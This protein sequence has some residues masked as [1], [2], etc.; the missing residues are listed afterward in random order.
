[1]VQQGQH[2]EKKILSLGNTFHADPPLLQAIFPSPMEKLPDELIDHILDCRCLPHIVFRILTPYTDLEPTEIA[3]LQGVSKRLLKLAR[4]GPLWRFQCYYDSPKATINRIGQKCWTQTPA[5]SLVGGQQSPSENT[6]MSKKARATDEWDLSEPSEKI[7]WYSEYVARHAQLSASWLSPQS[8]NYQDIRGAALFEDND[9]KKLVG[10]LEDGSLCLW[11]LNQ[12][13]GGS[14]R[15]AQICQK[16]ASSIPGILFSDSTTSSESS[17]SA[18]KRALS[19]SGVADCIS[20]DHSRK[21]AYVAVGDLLN[22]VDLDTL[23]V[24]SQSQ[25]A[26]SITALSQIQSPHQSLTV[27]TSFSLHILDPRCPSRDRSSSPMRSA[28]L[29]ES[30][31]FFPNKDIERNI[32]PARTF[33]IHPM[34]GFGTIGRD[35]QSPSHTPIPT[36]Y[37]QG[38]RN[39]TSYAQL[40]PA[41]L[42]ILHQTDNSIMVA[43]RFPS[44]LNYDRRYFPR[45]E[46][47]IHSSARLSALAYLPF[48]P[49]A[50]KYPS[51]VEPRGTLISCGEYNG[52]G[53]LELYSVPNNASSITAGSWSNN[54][55]SL[56]DTLEGDNMTITTD[57]SSTTNTSQ[58]QP[59]IY[60]FKN[61]Q[62]ISSAKLLSVATQGTRIVFSDADGGLKWVERDGKSIARRWNI[63]SYQLHQDSFPRLGTNSGGGG[64]STS[65]QVQRF[66]AAIHGEEVV[67][68]IIPVGTGEADDLLVWTGERV[69]LVGLG[70]NQEGFYDALEDGVAAGN[71]VGSEDVVK[72]FDG[73]VGPRMEGDAGGGDSGNGGGDLEEK[74]QEYDRQ[75]RR[76][77]ERQADE[78]NWMRRF[79]FRSSP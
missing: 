30:I 24:V 35:P 2:Q 58:D 72:R 50:I 56:S 44:I 49:R 52:R 11:D 37:M 7:D 67:R 47:V 21:R 59:G 14:S 43:G 63:N 26:W 51:I 34:N 42:S 12:N 3:L 45:L 1:M 61:R 40:E 5:Q 25:Y 16:S 33:Q 70:R 6:C 23:K 20:I 18:A 73:F 22:E 27:G 29:G 57:L 31:A 62:S 36:S 4:D 75:M 41:P 55:S 28:D 17:Q 65:R 69:G 9:R 8:V 71:A 53:S 32:H 66:E 15:H 13:E 79:G 10:P 77:L 76:A 38:R 54:A 46:Y 78:L 48:S 68:K 60:S 64:S 74:A 39:L 19:F